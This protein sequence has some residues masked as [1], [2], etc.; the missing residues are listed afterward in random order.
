[1][2]VQCPYCQQDM[3]AVPIHASG[4]KIEFKLRCQN[5]H[6]REVVNQ[7]TIE[8]LGPINRTEPVAAERTS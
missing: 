3:V 2:S 4:V 7:A 5:E 1:M 8:M 6:S